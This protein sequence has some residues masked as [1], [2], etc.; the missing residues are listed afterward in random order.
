VLQLAPRVDADE[1]GRD[2]LYLSRHL[3][4]RGWRPL[5][6][7]AGGDRLRAL[8]AAGVTHL[9]LQLERE[10][11][12]SRWRNARRLARSIREQGVALVHVQAASVADIAAAAARA[13]GV[14]LV[15]TLRDLDS[16]SPPAG[17]AVADA[18]RLIAVSEFLSGTWSERLRLAPECIRVVRRGID[19]AELDPERVRGH[20]VAA[21]A[22][23][24]NLPPG[25]RVVLVPSLPPEDRGHL[26][27]LRAVARLPR[28][29]CVTLFAGRFDQGD[30][31]GMELIEAVR[32]SGLG[33]RVR[34][35]GETD[36]LPA[37]LALADIVVVPATRAEPSG[38]LAAAAQAMGRPVI[39]THRGAL[40]EA[41][42]PAATGWLVPPDDHDELSRA[43]ALALAMDDTARQRL[44]ARARSFAIA[45]FGIE[46][47]CERILAVYRELLAAPLQRSK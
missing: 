47:S 33:E 45:E 38:M 28:V 43:M 3:R 7:S 32:R 24:W 23:R 1:I 27:M 13:T 14:P 46:V 42:L 39:V 15:A 18:D 8:A 26:L 22:D 19:P 30:R 9:P 5:V 31:Y 12:L 16:P 34:F 44:A 36:D 37:M 35:G 25:F 6:A 17:Q 21:L 29:D 11:R 41:V 10:G 40:P 4:A 2:T 20:R